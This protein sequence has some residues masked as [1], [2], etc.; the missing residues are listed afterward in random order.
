MLKDLSGW[1]SWL[2]ARREIKRQ[3]E[4]PKEVLL[5]LISGDSHVHDL[6]AVSHW[7]YKLPYV[8]IAFQADLLSWPQ[9]VEFYFDIKLHPQRPSFG[10][11]RQVIRLTGLYDYGETR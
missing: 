10:R 2:Q 4:I 5:T 11:K 7:F 8:F 6:A 1:M 9:Q 3:P